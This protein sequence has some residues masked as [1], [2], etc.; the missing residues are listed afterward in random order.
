V[1]DAPQRFDKVFCGCHNLCLRCSRT[2]FARRSTGTA[3]RSGDSLFFNNE[4]ADKC[5]RLFDGATTADGLT[6]NASGNAQVKDRSP[7][8][9]VEVRKN[10]PQFRK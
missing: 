2:R 7:K 9:E 4:T 8:I 5:G 1:F 3:S 10:Q 6:P